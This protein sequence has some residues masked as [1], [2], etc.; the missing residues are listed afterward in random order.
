MKRPTEIDS[1]REE[2][3]SKRFKLL[4]DDS[5]QDGE[6]EL[7]VNQNFARK[8]QYNKEREEKHR[9]AWLLTYM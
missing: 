7:K 4:D 9:C 2:S 1:A 5:D 3:P 8:F 6:V